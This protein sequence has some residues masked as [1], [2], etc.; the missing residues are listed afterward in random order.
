MEVPLS[1]EKELARIR[2]ILANAGRLDPIAR[3]H[4][5][6]ALYTHRND[7]P[8][9]L[10]GDESSGGRF[11]HVVEAVEAVM[12][13][14]GLREPAQTSIAEALASF[15]KTNT[16]ETLYFNYAQAFFCI[17]MWLQY[18]QERYIRCQLE[19]GL[20]SAY[21]SR[22]F[23]H[24]LHTKGDTRRGSVALF[25]DARLRLDGR[26]VKGAYGDMWPYAIAE[27][28]GL[29]EAVL[30]EHHQGPVRQERGSEAGSETW[31]ATPKDQ[32]FVYVID[33]RL[34]RCPPTLL[35]LGLERLLE[36]KVFMIHRMLAAYEDPLHFYLVYE[37]LGANFVTL[38]DQVARDMRGEGDGVFNEFYIAM[39]IERLL[40][41]IGACHELGL[42]HGTLRLTSC[43]LEL[44]S[45]GGANQ[46]E[47][48]KVIDF[49]LST[50]FH[51]SPT[52]PVLPPFLPLEMKREDP[53]PPF[54][55][56]LQA[57]G[58][59]MFILCS[60]TSALGPPSKEVDFE[61]AVNGQI[62]FTGDSW[63]AITEQAKRLISELFV[64]PKKRTRPRDFLNT[65]WFL[66]VNDSN[67]FDRYEPMK[68]K[69]RTQT[70]FNQL[71]KQIGKR[72]EFFQRLAELDA[73]T[74]GILAQGLPQDWVTFEELQ[75]QLLT[76]TEIDISH[77]HMKAIGQTFPDLQIPGHSARVQA[78]A[79]PAPP[80]KDTSPPKT[81]KHL[82]SPQPGP[83]VRRS[84]FNKHSS[85]RHPPETPSRPTPV[86][87]RAH[88]TD[89]HAHSQ[90]DVVLRAVHVPTFF[91]TAAHWRKARLIQQLWSVL[92]DFY[93]RPSYR[94]ADGLRTEGRRAPAQGSSPGPQFFKELQHGGQVRVRVAELKEALEE[95]RTTRGAITKPWKR[96]V[97]VLA[98]ESVMQNGEVPLLDMAECLDRMLRAGQFSGVASPQAA[99]VPEELSR[100]SSAVTS[101]PV[102]SPRSDGTAAMGASGRLALSL[103]MSLCAAP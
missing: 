4:W 67:R 88:V 43:Y 28:G 92:R 86:S 73:E 42:M 84:A 64:A 68:H 46:F 33:K 16:M 54:A 12:Q 47:T 60:G 8:S 71:Q 72:T 83:G 34:A 31:N 44:R 15:I 95:D 13:R 102:V 90:V 89:N 75:A 69:K 5:F 93:C 11:Q 96:R 45:E 10:R 19:S 37:P 70:A 76:A 17:K 63:A 50:I 22:S 30:K 61:K 79:G 52:C 24:T 1:S 94:L 53:T 51:R 81:P 66:F 103:D 62:S 32:C 77:Q 27:P 40:V 80:R 85:P 6:R 87:A 101:S 100:T 38:D 20:W 39:I 55:H 25:W 98:A 18:L 9:P 36:C 48:L 58:E 65:S 21:F 26:P 14:L 91:Q 82:V 29:A 57:I 59:I 23:L 3:E 7:L 56:D 78:R 41:T 97:I 74:A 49:G 99:R 2:I 35:A